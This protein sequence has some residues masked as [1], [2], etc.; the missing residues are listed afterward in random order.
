MLP[1]DL[2]RY[3]FWL[4][5]RKGRLHLVDVE[6]VRD[7]L[8]RGACLASVGTLETVLFQ[9]LKGWLQNVSK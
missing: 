5:H 8:E 2:H 7:A 6:E 1:E 9:A 3:L 4:V